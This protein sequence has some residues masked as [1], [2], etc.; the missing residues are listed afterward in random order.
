MREEKVEIGASL[1][2]MWLLVE[3]GVEAVRISR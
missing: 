1:L 3:M 2:V